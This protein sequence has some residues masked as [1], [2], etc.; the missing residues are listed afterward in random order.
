MMAVLIL[1]ISVILI[2]IALFVRIFRI[3]REV[4]EIEAR[5]QEHLDA[6]AAAKAT[7]K[8]M[9]EQRDNR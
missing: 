2:V 6:I 3:M 8:A 1:S 5:T 9:D 7:L 4:G